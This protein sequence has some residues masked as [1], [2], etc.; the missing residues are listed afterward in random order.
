MGNLLTTQK[1]NNNNNNNNKC[2]DNTLKISENPICLQ[3]TSYAKYNDNI[4][5]NI[6]DVIN[7]NIIDVDKND[8]L[9]KIYKHSEHLQTILDE[10]DVEK[11]ISDILKQEY[12]MLNLNITYEKYIEYL[13]NLTNND[14]DDDDDNNYNNIQFTEE[15]IAQHCTLYDYFLFN[16]QRDFLDFVFDT[17]ISKQHIFYDKLYLNQ[18]FHNFLLLKIS[19]KND[20]NNETF[21]Y[22][23][24][25]DKTICNEI[26]ILYSEH[27]EQKLLNNCINITCLNI[28]DNEKITDVNHFKLLV[29][30]NISWDCGVDQKGIEQLLNIKKLNA[31]DNNKITCINHLLFLKE[32][33]MS[34]NCGI[35]K[36]NISPVLNITNL[37]LECNDDDV[38]RKMSYIDKIFNIYHTSFYLQNMVEDNANFDDIDEVC[39]ITYPKLNLNISYLQYI[40]YLFNLTHNF[41]NIRYTEKNIWKYVVLCDYFMLDIQEIFSNYVIDEYIFK[42]NKFYNELCCDNKF[43]TTVLNSIILNKLSKKNNISNNTFKYIF[44]LNINM[45]KKIISLY[46]QHIEQNLLDKCINITKLNICNNDKITNIKCLSFLKELNVSDNCQINLNDISQDIIVTKLNE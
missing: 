30:L 5:S 40:E 25:T 18:P 46:S 13:L 24:E 9:L 33:D 4:N 35:D 1:N 38:K 44:V 11:N 41:K 3:D 16:N 36:N 42:H 14:D 8:N 26:T 39:K 19:K 32:L 10:E 6:I 31:S 45:C 23:F 34:F 12:N 27:I 28:C 22:I 17:H 7:I 15:N 20:I 29:D 21:K 37:N 2:C 43:S